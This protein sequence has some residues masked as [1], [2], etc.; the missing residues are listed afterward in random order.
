MYVKIYGAAWRT[1]E[2]C[3]LKQPLRV[4]LT[5]R[6]RLLISDAMEKD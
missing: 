6:V 4:E 2:L 5:P 3:G 1:S